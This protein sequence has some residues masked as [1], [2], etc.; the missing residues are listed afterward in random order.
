VRSAMEGLAACY[1]P[2]ELSR[3]G[4]QLYEKFQHS[5]PFGREG[6]RGKAVLEIE[7]ILATL[8]NTTDHDYNSAGFNTP[9]RCVSE[10]VKPFSFRC[11]TNPVMAEH[12]Q[13]VRRITVA[14]AEMQAT[15]N[16]LE[17]ALVK[18]RQLIAESAEAVARAMRIPQWQR[19]L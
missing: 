10:T 19:L 13:N 16:E 5:R 14:V 11:E 15:A 1:E 12:R 3:I 17:S 8:P 4:L 7:N 18:S 6:R 9:L 2:T